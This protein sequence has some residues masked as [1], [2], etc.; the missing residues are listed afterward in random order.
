MSSDEN[1]CV[2]I[3]QRRQSVETMGFC[4][5][6]GSDEGKDGKSAGNVM[7]AS[8]WDALEIILVHVLEK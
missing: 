2:T 7:T 3:L 6:T 4:S 1:G 5:R 8:F